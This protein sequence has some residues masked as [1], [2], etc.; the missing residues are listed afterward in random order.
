M[1]RNSQERYLKI[2]SGIYIFLF[3]GGPFSLALFGETNKEDIFQDE[4]QVLK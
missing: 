1:S 3:L 2:Y 4:L